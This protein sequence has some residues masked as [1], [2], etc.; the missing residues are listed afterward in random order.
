[1][2]NDSAGTDTKDIGVACMAEVY[3]MNPDKTFLQNLFCKKILTKPFVAPTGC[4]H[5]ILLS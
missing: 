2:G 4:M 1:M 5:S 3:S